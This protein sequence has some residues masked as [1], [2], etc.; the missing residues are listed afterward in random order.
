MAATMDGLEEERKFAMKPNNK[1]KPGHPNMNFVPESETKQEETGGFSWGSIVGVLV[2]MFVGGPVSEGGASDKMDTITALTRGDLS[3][4]EM[5]SIG[6]EFVLNLVRGGDINGIDRV[7]N[8]SPLEGILATVISFFTD[9]DDPSE[10]G[11][12]AKQASELFGL[13]VTLLD[14]L[15]TSFSQRSL[16]ARSLGTSD[17]MADAAVAAT[18]MLKTYIRNYN[19]EDDLCMQKFLCQANQNCVESTGDSG[20]LFCQIGTY[21]MSYLLEHQTYTPFEIFNDAG[22]RGRVGETCDEIFAECNEL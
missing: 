13:V 11:V 17:P 18:T 3:W 6:L 7:D 14:T 22:R 12:M 8:G 15:R 21:G 16:E 4:G 1:M 9:N 2:Q 10:V 5:F 19:T 20:Y